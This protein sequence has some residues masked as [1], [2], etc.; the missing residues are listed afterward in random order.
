[1]AQSADTPVT[2]EEVVV[3]ANKRLENVQEVPSSVSVASGEQL[4]ERGESQLTDYAAYM[5]GFNAT[6]LGAPGL[7]SVSLRGISTGAATSAVGTY[8]DD[9][10]VGGS[11][12]W[13]VASTSLLDMLPYDLDR[14]EVLRGPQGTLYGAG[15]MG[16]II[17]YVLKNPSTTDFEAKVGDEVSTI[18]GADKLGNAVYAR[19][20]LPL[21]HDAL[22]LSVSFFDK[23]TPGYMDNI[24]NGDKDTND[25]REYGGR[26]ALL[27]LPADGLSVKLTAL[28]QKIEVDDLA[29]QQYQSSTILPSYAPAVVL[30]P[31][32]PLPALKEDLAFESPY[33]Q[34]IAFFSA[35]V[36]WNVGPVDLVSATSWSSQKSQDARDYTP[37]IGTILPFIGGT[38]TGL[39]SFGG[40][41]GFNK[42][43][44]EFR[45]VSPQGKPVEWLVGT[46]LTHE[47]SFDNQ[48][49]KEYNFDYTP[50]AYAFPGWLDAQ[51]PET[52]DEYAAFGDV[53]WHLTDAF[54][55]GAG[56]RYAHNDPNWNAVV[57]PGPL[58]NEVGDFHVGT[59]E[60]VATWMGDLE[61]HFYKD[62]M[63]YARVATGYR[64]GG[65]NSPL[66]GVP[67]M[68]GAD[69]LT[70]YELGLKSTFL[71][72]RAQIDAAVYRIDWRGIQ[73][74]ASIN[75]LGYLANGG[76]AVS[77]GV[78]FAGTYSPI[79][80][81]T[82]GLNA[83][84]TDSHLTSVIPEAS[85]LLT[86][87]QLPDVPKLS[88]SAT[89]D[90]RWALVGNWAAHVGGGYRYVG[91][92]WLSIVESAS[93]ATTPT[94][95]TGG[96][97]VIDLNANVQNDH[98]TFKAYVRNL[99]NNHAIV[100][101]AAGPVGQSLV[102]RNSATGVDSIDASILQPRTIGVGFDYTF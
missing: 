30:A 34:R 76:A 78:E 60:G 19:V 48:L 88:A 41:Y 4:I 73:L 29:I 49:G 61:Y 84:Y 63:T 44:Q 23:M 86:G 98:L 35:T 39:A 36:D 91:P 1:M 72:R 25:S 43:T 70:N 46:F 77:Q 10:P 69:K 20:N 67:A 18:D 27:W 38:A 59:H 99:A 40:D 16:G 85:F 89:A 82:L 45:V 9:V 55:V 66:A 26:A 97:S 92:Q 37:Q 74:P 52:F 75:G 90:Y 53:T 6:N 7:T 93:A 58:V 13:E 47:N 57:A 54:S 14:I 101:A 17:K 83:A 2:L 28:V 96:Y 11:S 42:L 24:Y 5:P 8:I 21:V 79:D 33:D 3:T 87:Y 65:P 64:P 56:A 95:R 12:G 71:D 100:G 50:M 31:G 22:G 102:I 15:S 68:V 32:A 94:V 80:R 62:T 51:F 81:L